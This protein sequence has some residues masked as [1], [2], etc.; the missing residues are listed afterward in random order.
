[1]SI[2]EALYEPLV[3]RIAE[4][5]G[6]R[7]G[8]RNR[9]LL[10]A[11]V[12]VARGSMAT[13]RFVETILQGDEDALDRLLELLRVGESRF[14]RHPRQLRAI[15]RIALPQLVA[16]AESEMRPLRI[17]SAGCASGEEAYTLVLLIQQAF[18]DVRF[19]VLATDLSDEALERARAGVYAEERVRD[20]PPAIARTAFIARGDRF[21]VRP[22]VRRFVRFAKA[23]LLGDDYPE[24]QD[25]VLCRNVLIYFDGPTRAQVLE[26][27][28]HSVSLEGYVA[29][30][31]ADRVG[32]TRG[33]EPIRTEEG[34]LYKRVERRPS[35]LPPPPRTRSSETPAARERRPEPVERTSP[36]APAATPISKRPRTPKPAAVP[37]RGGERAARPGVEPATSVRF[38]LEGELTGEEGRRRAHEVSSAMLSAGTHELDLRGLRFADEPVAQELRR[39]AAA[40]ASEGRTLTL[41]V[42]GPGMERFLRRHRVV[43]PA[44][45]RSST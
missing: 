11:R 22:E 42:D 30:G 5:A 19:E 37:S 32:Q 24:A 2:P 28:F 38:S 36:S 40:L 8:P 44:K 3:R 17:W 13:S 12:E 35:V 39:V 18:P 21:E 34:T 23:N 9:W 43:P 15:R 7:I 41:Y 14:W 31:Y 26:R 10:D 1:M 25:L 4:H 29:L 16:H 45:T 27:L 33:V 20:V 6:M